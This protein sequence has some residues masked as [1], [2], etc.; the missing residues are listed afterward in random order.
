MKIKAV[1]FD[2]FITEA[3]AKFFR[4]YVKYAVP[5]PSNQV[6]LKTVNHTLDK[7][8]NKLK[9]ESSVNKVERHYFS[10]RSPYSLHAKIKKLAE[11]EFNVKLKYRPDAYGHI[12]HYRKQC[13]GLHWHNE[14]GMAYVSASVNITPD[15]M[16]EGADFQIKNWDGRTPYKSLILYNSIMT[17]R[18]TELVYGEKMSFVMWLPKHDQKVNNVPWKME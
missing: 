3:E 7:D 2:N 6:S 14:P 9:E 16:Y 12:M 13:D 15:H 11:S 17:H 8:G 1:V 5:N 18:V 10:L 4:D